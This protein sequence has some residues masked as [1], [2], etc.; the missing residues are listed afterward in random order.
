MRNA[1]AVINIL[2]ETKSAAG[3]VL[4]FW[5]PLAIEPTVG[6][7]APETGQ[8]PYGNVSTEDPFRNL[9]NHVHNIMTVVSCDPIAKA[10]RVMARFVI[11]L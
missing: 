11:V 5:H 3:T 7:G 1:S 9:E 4:L 6:L 10:V 2:G 8:E